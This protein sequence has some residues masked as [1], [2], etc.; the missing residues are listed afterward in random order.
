MQIQSVT[1]HNFR[2]IQHQTINLDEYTALIGPNNTGK[3]NIIAALLFFYDEIRL[4]DTDFLYCPECKGEELYVEV[5][6]AGLSEELYNSLPEQYKLP[7]NRL[8][9][10]RQAARGSKAI[11]KGV[12]YKNGKE[13]LHD[14]DFFGAKGVGKGKIG[15]VIFIPALKNVAEELKTTGSAT[16]AKLLKEVVGPGIVDLEEYTAFSEAVRGLSDRLKGSPIEDLKDWDGKSISGIECFLDRE[17]NIWN[18]SVRVDLKP[19]DPAKLAQQAATVSIME[20]GHVPFPVDSKGQGL[21]RSLEVA[22]VKLWAEVVRRK[23]ISQDSKKKIFRPEFTLILI[24]EPESFQHPQQQYRF[25]EDLREL[26]GQENQQLIASTHSPYFLTPHIEDLPTIV[27]VIKHGNISHIK[28]LSKEFLDSIA[29]EHENVKFRYHLWLNQERN[30]MFFADTVLLVEGPTE[31]VLFNW[32]LQNG[33]GITASH[34]Q[35]SFVMDCGGKFQIDKFMRL[36]GEFEIPH[37]VIHDKDD[38]AKPKHKAAN[39]KIQ[40]CRNEFT[41]EVLIIEPDLEKF[42]GVKFENI[43]SDKPPMMLDYLDDSDQRD[44]AILEDFARFIVKHIPL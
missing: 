29:A 35:K 30:E 14:S 17:L 19:L 22:L 24:E 37:L 8:K 12:T 13:E 33:E 44:D 18:C 3:S 40:S 9:V 4:T 28:C 11:Y 23:E 42:L 10:R 32:I 43:R 7:E 34:R 25:Y 16:L 20:E 2:S 1:I 27:R 39:E 15:N 26:S 36:L 5:E 38:E 6:F 31:K 41:K 21:Q